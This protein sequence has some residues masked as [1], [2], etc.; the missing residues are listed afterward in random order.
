MDTLSDITRLH[1]LVIGAGQAGLSVGYHLARRGRPFLIIDA[2]QRIGDQWRRRWDSL[3]LF[4][5]ARFDGLD[6]LPF[7][8]PPDSFPTKDAMADYLASYAAHF[9]LPVACG[10]RVERLWR[11]GSRYIA[12]AG[13][14][15]FE[16]DHVVVAMANFQKPRVPP[17]ARDLDPAIV[18]LHSAEY[19]RPGQLRDGAVLVVG[20]GNSG[21]EIALEAA[22]TH[23]TWLAGRDVGQVPFGIGS[24]A[25]R[26]LLPLVFRVV[27]HRVLT[28]DTPIG[29]R[30][31]P[32]L[33]GK[34]GLLI[35]TKGRDLAAAGV[36]RLPRVAG[37]QHGM[38]LLEGGQRIDVA[39]VIW[40]TGFDP[41]FSWID[42]PVF[43]ERGE[44]KQ[45]R[46]IVPGEPGLYFAGL[47]FLYAF[48]STM[49]H[50]VGRDADRVAATI[51]A[52]T[53]AASGASA[54]VARVPLASPA[55]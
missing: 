54:R 29:R 46:G 39:N 21:A 33:V 30:A 42:L 38:P 32:S 34:G 18:Q 2:D 27:F 4:T 47:H 3:R 28:T 35:R 15:R 11:E 45:E 16:A 52:R 14:R 50:G 12:Q 9:R 19:Q 5:P 1:T 31:R 25:A 55:R 6:G 53:K 24:A 48:S 26:I 36:T 49:I 44:P 51:D 23:R 13:G 17:F 37:V 43:N 7:P 10:V 41:G 40:C 8:A 22:R 20:A